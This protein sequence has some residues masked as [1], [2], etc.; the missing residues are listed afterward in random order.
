MAIHLQAYEVLRALLA[1]GHRVAL[2]VIFNAFHESKSLTSAEVSELR[3]IRELG[4]HVFDPIYPG[5]YLAAPGSGAWIRMVAALRDAATLLPGW[6]SFHEFYPSERVGRLVQARA[7]S[8]GCDGVISFG[9]P[10]ALAALR[11][12]H[13]APVAAFQGDVD[14]MPAAI[15]LTGDVAFEDAG[16]SAWGGTLRRWRERLW[17]RR[18]ERAHLALMREVGAIVNATAA[19][20][21]FYERHSRGRVSYAGTTWADPA[22][23]GVP[24][25]TLDPARSIGRPVKIIGHIGHLGM[26]GST[27]GLMFLVRQVLP[28][29]RNAMADVPYEVHII[30]GGQPAAPVRERLDQPGVVMR[31]FVEQLDAELMSSD[32]FVFLNNAGPLVAAYSRHI[33]AW[34]TGLCLV[35]HRNSCRAIP[36]IRHGENALVGSTPEVIA[37]QIRRAATDAGLN[38]R[39]RAAGRRTY[40]IRFSPRVLAAALVDALGTGRPDPARDAGA[41]EPLKLVEAA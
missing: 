21:P 36:E 10:E 26:T 41:A 1:Q 38:R 23:P 32:V 33:L 3:H 2:Q 31:G 30:G 13:G 40:E 37:Q 22:P 29:L 28:V 27:Y 18:F 7:A 35:V 9:S 4:V 39:L 34:A 14:F 25:P 15:R 6:T 16:N 24:L 12:W 20:L 5:A 8:W 11:G 17:L 19:N